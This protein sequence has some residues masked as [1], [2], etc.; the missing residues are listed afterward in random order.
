MKRE[1]FLMI[2]P[3]LVLLAAGC[4]AVPPTAPT[5]PDSPE[6]PPTED[7]MIKAATAVPQPQRAALPD[8]GPAPEI[9]NEVWVNADAPVTLAASR[10]KV[11]LVEFWT[12][13]C[14]NCQRVIPY[15]QAWYETYAG[16]DFTV[17][18]VHYPEFAHERDYDNV[19]A[20]TERLG[21]TYPVAIDNDRLTWGAYNQRYWPTTYLIDKEGNIRYQHIGE[22]A[23]QETEAAIQALMA[24][25]DPS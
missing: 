2:L 5:A 13:G 11:V 18:S 16:D 3:V 17:I 25:P 7:A 22:G 19:V 14:I 4:T 15:V 1:I 9:R 23:Y 24:E 8:L 21:V 20:A 12:F 10:G 6:P